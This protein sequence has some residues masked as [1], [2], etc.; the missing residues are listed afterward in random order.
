MNNPKIIIAGSGSIG[1]F[2]GG[3]L[4]AAGREVTFLGRPRIAKQL[5]THGLSL[6][7]YSGIDVQVSPENIE[8]GE[9]PSLLSAAD[10][11][12]V[13][14]KS[15][16]TQTMSEL[17]HDHAKKDAIVVSL[18]NGVRNADIIREILPRFDVR[19]GM[20][21]FNVVQ[22]D[23]GR[24]HQGTS[25]EIIIEAGDPDVSRVLNVTG[26]TAKASNEMQSVQWGKLLMNLNNALNALSDLPLVEELSD[27]NWRLLLA[28]QMS[29]AL[30][31]LKAAGIM[32]KPPS[33]VPAGLIPKILRL[34]TP[35]FK[36]VAKQML[37]MDPEAR[38][39]MWEDLQ[40]GRKTEVDE[41]QGEVVRLGQKHGVPTPINNKI[42][43]EINSVENSS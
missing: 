2:V 5:N 13:C 35:I 27:R 25:G 7:S 15:S 31:A 37:A 21:G 11:I 18:Q 23:G 39:S 1:C 12:L 14:V 24:F 8:I 20:V 34:P 3:L 6:T 41:L 9:D 16:A 29:E 17:I 10:L 4:K 33:P 38:S 43:A 32:P 22:M 36:M 40:N 30:A 19:S 42:L 26:L 28:D